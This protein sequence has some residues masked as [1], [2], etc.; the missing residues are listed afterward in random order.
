M[1]WWWSSVIIFLVITIIVAA[2]IIITMKT[3]VKG[4]NQA[5]RGDGHLPELKTVVVQGALT[6]HPHQFCSYF[7]N[8]SHE[9]NVVLT[10]ASFPYSSCQALPV[11]TGDS[12]VQFT[13]WTPDHLIGFN[14]KQGVNISSNQGNQI[15][16]LICVSQPSSSGAFKIFQ[17]ISSF[18]DKETK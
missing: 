12:T 16:H 4:G 2:I 1:I 13:D 18:R 11:T 9:V 7:D 5:Q 17:I 3:L 15:W 14:T 8:I 10:R 6:G